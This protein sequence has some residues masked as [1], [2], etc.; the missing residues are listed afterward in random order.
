MVIRRQNV[1]SIVKLI[2]SVLIIGAIILTVYLI[3]RRHGLTNLSRAQIQEF[4]ASTG[5]VAP[6]V[7]IALSFAQVTLVPI[8]GAVT[9]IAGS[10]LFGAWLSFLY[11]Y[12]GMIV[13]AF[14]AYALGKWFGRPYINWLA[15]GKEQAD[16][17]IK[18]LKGRENA[19]LFFA[20]LLPFFPDDLLCSVA[21]ILTSFSAFV[22]MQV[23]T[24]ATS[25][26]FTIL[27]TSGEVI[28]YNTLGIVIISV[29]V[30]CAVIVFILG[31]KYA[32]KFSVLFDK[33]LS[34]FKFKRRKSKR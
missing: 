21:G 29:I 7:F 6:L 19:Y 25:I 28:P 12:I 30:V 9:I 33:F 17:W 20:F 23:I 26:G 34:F 1:K 32:D 16:G 2:A 14:F 4:I 22:F 18:K 24:R 3:L 13:G 10:Y 15:G 31:I 11:S 27:V 5:A 8:P